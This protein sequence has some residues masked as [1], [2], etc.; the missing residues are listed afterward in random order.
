MDQLNVDRI[1]GPDLH[2]TYHTVSPR[3]DLYK[4]PKTQMP[5]VCTFI[6]QQD[7]GIWLQ[8]GLGLVP[9]SSNLQGWQVFPQP[10]LQK[11]IYKELDLL[12][13]SSVLVRLYTPVHTWRKADSFSLHQEVRRCLC[14]MSSLGSSSAP[15]KLDPLSHLNS[16]TS[17]QRLM[18]PLKDIMKSRSSNELIQA[19]HSAVL[20]F[21]HASHGRGQTDP[22]L[23]MR[24]EAGKPSCEILGEVTFAEAFVW[25]S[26]F[27][28]E[29]I[30]EGWNPQLLLYR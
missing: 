3:I 1:L 22:C 16:D 25:H 18:N 23:S 5:S 29:G 19:E 4:L 7:Q 11:R 17:P 24:K 30:T 15:T 8:L 21:R 26:V 9:F 12:P 2:C 20:Y 10:L 6:H 28:K 14:L 13:F 27:H